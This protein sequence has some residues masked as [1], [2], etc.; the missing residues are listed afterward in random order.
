MGT[1]KEL[2]DCILTKIHYSILPMEVMLMN[3]NFEDKNFINSEVTAKST[4]FTS[5]ESYHRYT[6]QLCMVVT[7]SNKAIIGHIHSASKLSM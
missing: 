3:E 7:I 2:Y 6:T 4:K 5:L 1:W